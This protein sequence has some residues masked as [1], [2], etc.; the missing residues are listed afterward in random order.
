MTKQHYD[1]RNNTVEMTVLITPDMANFS[2]NMHGGSLLKLIDQ[3]A[4]TCAARYCGKYAVTLSVDHVQFKEAIKI[5]ELVT[6][7][8]SVNHVGNTSMEVGV[9]IVAEDIQTNTQRHT[10]SCYLTMVAVDENGKPSKV[11]PLKLVDSTQKARF[12]A[13]KLR[14]ELRARHN[15]HLSALHSKWK[16]KI[17]NLTSEQIDAEFDKYMNTDKS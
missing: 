14:K 12:I 8:A 16:D 15:E 7:L 4:Y 2:G 13:A 1:E 6:L 11:P 17:E 9:K 3:V 10:N 5:G